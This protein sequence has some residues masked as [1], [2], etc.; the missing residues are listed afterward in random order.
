[1][2]KI[3]MKD[4]RPNPENPFPP[5]SDNALKDLAGKIKR[6]PEFLSLRPIVLDGKKTMMILGGNKRFKALE[7]IGYEEIP[8]E[9]I[10]YADDLTDEQRRRFI[11]ADNFNATGEWDMDFVSVEEANEWSIP[12]KRKDEKI[13]GTVEFSEF[14]NE[15]NNYVVLTFDNDIDW[16]AAVT[17]FGITPKTRKRNNGKPWSTGVGRVIDGAEYIKK[18]KDESI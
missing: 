5:K 14:I 1:M 12:K 6:D 7:M 4:I 17:H 18:S 13:D 10:K 16:L 8:E 15:S 11:F 2:K 9:W 3:K